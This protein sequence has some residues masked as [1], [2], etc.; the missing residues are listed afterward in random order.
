MTRILILVV[1]C[2][3]GCK[4]TKQTNEFR[5]DSTSVNLKRIQTTWDKEIVT[6]WE[7][8]SIAFLPVDAPPVQIDCT[9]TREKVII[10]RQLVREKGTEAREEKEET[11]V[12]IREETTTKKNTGKGIV[13]ILLGACITLLIIA[14]AQAFYIYLRR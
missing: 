4:T 9:A 14:V 3:F 6:Q 11:S 8:P 7:I 2:L 1:L 10:V 5:Q 12:A 13:N